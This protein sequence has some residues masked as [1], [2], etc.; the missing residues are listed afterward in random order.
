MTPKKYKLIIAG[1]VLLVILLSVRVIFD[2]KFDD[3]D[4]YIEKRENYKGGTEQFDED[5][6][7]LVDWEM[8]IKRKI[9]MLRMK[10]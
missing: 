2:S 6:H 3:F 9:Q 10:K 8:I 1:L 4:R 5:F 7:R